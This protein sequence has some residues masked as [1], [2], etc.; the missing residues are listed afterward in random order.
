MSSGAPLR[1]RALRS[2]RFADSSS[3]KAPSVPSVGTYPGWI[4]L[5]RMPNAPSSHA[6]ARTIMSTAAFVDV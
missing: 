5:T 2:S 1:L 4:A 6:A 3:V